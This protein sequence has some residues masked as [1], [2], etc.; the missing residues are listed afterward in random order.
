MKRLLL[1][2]LLFVS[3]ASSP[4]QTQF[5]EATSSFALELVRDWKAIS[6]A[7]LLLS[8]V[9]VALAYGF[10]IA[11][12]LPQ[13]KAWANLELRQII[14]NALIIAF[15]IASIAFIDNLAR[16]LVEESGIAVPECAAGR[17]DCLQGV[18][19]TYIQ[20]YYQMA[21]NELKAVYLE[22]VADSRLASLRTS[23]SCYSIIVP[24]PC[25]QFAINAL[26]FAILYLDVDYNMVV[27]EHLLNIAA[28]LKSQEFFVT[29]IGYNWGPILLALGVVA[30][31]FYLTRRLGG[32]L[33]AASIGILFFLPFMYLFNWLTLDTVLTSSLEGRGASATC[34]S[35]C[36]KRYPV[37][38]SGSQS[39]T[40]EDLAGLGFSENEINAL[41]NGS[42]SSLSKEGRT[43]YSCF[44]DENGAKSEEQCPRTCREIPYPQ[45]TVCAD[46][47]VQKAC[48]EL[49]KEC[50]VE[51]VVEGEDRD[52]LL[53]GAAAAQCPD[54]CKITPPL[55]DDCGATDCRTVPFA[56]RLAYKQYVLDEDGVGFIPTY[57]FPVRLDDEGENI[58]RDAEKCFEGLEDGTYLSAYSSCGYIVPKEQSCSE[59]CADCPPPCRIVYI[60]ASESDPW[61]I[62]CRDYSVECVSCPVTCKADVTYDNLRKLKSCGSC[63]DYKRVV[64]FGLPEDYFEGACSL[65]QCPADLEHRVLIPSSS[66]EGCMFS[67]ERA[68]FNPPI[69]PNCAEV[70]S[71]E[72]TTYAKSPG[73]YSQ[74]GGEGMAGP[75]EVKNISKLMLPG[76]L[77]PLFNLIATLVFVKGLS[78][79]LG[80]DIEI[81]G[82]R[83]LV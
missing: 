4:A 81:P 33:I 27:F 39:F 34:P 55:K 19:K 13:V 57:S 11:F 65:D 78:E 61:Y 50:K 62:M 67:D 53:S 9:I 6:I 76:Y 69:T 70:C 22:N 18:A 29:V 43:Y 49:I 63:P 64:G 17:A 1:L 38:F 14:A 25:F 42:A 12:E 15:L 5:E 23:A 82:I 40:D 31:S 21:E 3:F 66:C 59:L 10:G 28:S 48:G 74:L 47:D 54:A 8:T 24:V 73:R 20:Q 46:E 44:V 36:M 60:P 35:E 7:V 71:P 77:L 16:A 51:R 80:G 72:Q 30:R 75:E 58:C 56:C 68:Y 37:A 26:P 32:L 2:F 52:A 45:T 83:R 41:S 79:L